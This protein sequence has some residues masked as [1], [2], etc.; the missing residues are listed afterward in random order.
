MKSTS[1]LMK[2]LVSS[3][4]AL[5][6]VSTYAADYPT[7]KPIRMIVGYTTGG[8]AD[9]LIRPISDRVSKIIGQQII[10][11]YKPGAG[12][13]V[14]LELLTRAPADGYTLHIVDS[15]PLTI[16]PSLRKTPYDPVKDFTPVAMLAGGGSVIVTLPNSPAKDV[17]T[18]IELAK[19]NPQDWSYGTSGVGGV[20]HLAA[21]QFKVAT[22]LKI[23]HVPYKGGAPAV[24]ELLGGH[25]PMLFSSLGS[26]A[27][28]IEAGRL[29]PL[30]VTSL[31]R[32]GLFPDVPTLAESGFPGFDSSIWY[33]II[34]PAGLPKEVMDKLV[35]AFKQALA[36]PGQ[37]EAIRKEGY[38]AMPMTPVEMQKKIKDDIVQWDKV[39]KET[40]VKID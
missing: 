39:I 28:N 2:G 37:I 17:K 25:I 19:K 32:S 31:N 6:A 30:A 15:G 36:D 29:K 21:E 38:D 34:A 24:I 27:T 1:I 23:D 14:A 18:L 16:L 7:E 9:K 12:G 26:A 5:A 33:G 20:A 10:M 11:D 40:G 13:A 22:G 4:L 8:A 3:I 35:P